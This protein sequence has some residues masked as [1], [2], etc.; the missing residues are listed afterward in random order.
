MIIWA[1]SSEDFRCNLPS[2]LYRRFSK[3][4]H[5]LSFINN[6]EIRFMNLLYYK[7]LEDD[8][9]R[10]DSLEGEFKQEFNT[11]GL[12]LYV[13]AAGHNFVLNDVVDMK[14][15]QVLPDMDAYFISCYSTQLHE[16]QEKN[17]GEYLVTINNSAEFIK[18][19]NNAQIS[20]YIA[21]QEIIYYE[22]KDVATPL[23]KEFM[24]S[25]LWARKRDNY[26]HDY[27]FRIALLISNL[28]K[29]KA[30]LLKDKNVQNNMDKDNN[31]M[32]KLFWRANLGNLT[33]ITT[34][35]C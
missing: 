3:K 20:Q 8:D 27:E 18:R 10:N 21:W 1:K 19:F 34:L 26:K 14:I 6:G 28:N 9:T 31:I 15:E 13:N 33:D 11:K 22:H 7:A 23:K 16:T 12:Q 4:E 29:A 24:N 35:I 17:Y 25:P 30:T 5:A 2:V 32:K